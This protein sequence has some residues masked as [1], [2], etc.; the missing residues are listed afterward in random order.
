M[1]DL[2]PQFTAMMADLPSKTPSIQGANRH[3][4]QQYRQLLHA[5]EHDV[6]AVRLGFSGHGDGNDLGRSVRVQVRARTGP[7]RTPSRRCDAGVPVG[8]TV[9]PLLSIRRAP[10]IPQ[11]APID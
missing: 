9:T 3:P 8:P 10:D 2:L 1:K 4:E 6:Q 5:Q 7:C 11:S